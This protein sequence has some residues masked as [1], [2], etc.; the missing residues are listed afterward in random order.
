VVP[1]LVQRD[2][3]AEAMAREAMRIL[4]DSEYRAEMVRGL[5][6]V[7]LRLSRGGASERAA[8]IALEMIE[9]SGYSNKC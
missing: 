2:C 9:E 1:E 6:D 7:R 5:E 8:M 3:T 4:D